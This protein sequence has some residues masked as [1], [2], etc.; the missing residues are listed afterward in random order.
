MR[1]LEEELVLRNPEDDEVHDQEDVVLPLRTWMYSEEYPN[2]VLFSVDS[3]EYRECVESGMWYANPLLD[4]FGPPVNAQTCYG[5]PLKPVDVQLAE[6][7]EV[8]EEED[9]GGPPLPA[10]EVWPEEEEEEEQGPELKMP[11]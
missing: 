3:P 7:V 11:A 2:G 6:F 1:E 9:D 10:G 8:L 5:G 4:K